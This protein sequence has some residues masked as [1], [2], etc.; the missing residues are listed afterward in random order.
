VHPDRCNHIVSRWAEFL[1]ALGIRELRALCGVSMIVPDDWKDPGPRAPMCPDCL[2][3]AARGE[4]PA[5]RP[6][7]R[8]PQAAR[9]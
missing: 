7:S 5:W 6:R 3:R 4:V 1:S 9:R 8:K 2:R